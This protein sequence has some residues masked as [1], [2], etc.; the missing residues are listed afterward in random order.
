MQGFSIDGRRVGPGEPPY[1]I[2]EL[3]AN[4]GGD[5]ARARRIIELAAEAGA[6][7]IKFQVYT[8]D[9]ITIRSEKPDFLIEGESLWTGKRLYDLYK[10]A[11]T[12][13]EWFPE[14]F[15][16][17][18]ALGITPFASPFDLEAVKLLQSLD[19]PAYKIA[20]FEAVDLELI[21]AC[22]RT[23]KPVIISTGMCDADDIA[24]ALGTARKAGGTDIALLKCT[25]SYP[26]TAAEANLATIPA[27][28]RK[29]GVP[30]GVSDHTLGTVVSVAACAL[31]ACL[32]EKHVIDA[33]APATADSAFSLLPD[34]LGRLVNET[35]A[36]HEAV[37]RESYGPGERERASLQYR[38]SLY[39]VADIKAGA[40]LT[41]SNVR[42]IRPGMGL[43]PKHLPAVLGR[44]AKHDIETGTPLSWDLIQ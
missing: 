19:A 20:S 8:P 39:A 36:A 6:D 15:A 32:V 34:D 4:H 11:A 23:G 42:W 9:S 43:V 27:M 44:K 2:A 35:R 29:F 33:R 1:I 16:H 31:G 40:E 30:V 28:A 26:A 5:L 3:S 18:R 37:G 10:E 7:S 22:A 14:L 24:D 17:A 12:P 13:Y 41:R 21:E 38:R 25:S